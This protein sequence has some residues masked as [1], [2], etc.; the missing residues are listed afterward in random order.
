MNL[1]GQRLGPYLLE[2]PV[3]S[4]AHG[5]VWR[6]SRSD[7]LPVA[8]K[9]ARDAVGKQA[10]NSEIEALKLLGNHPNIV[11]PLS[12]DPGVEPPYIA[13]ALQP[14]GTLRELLNRSG[15]T[16][17]QHGMALAGSV[18]AGL[19]H[20]HGKGITHGDVKPENVMLDAMGQPRLGDFG[21]S[22]TTTPSLSLSG[23]LATTGAPTGTVAYM[24]PSQ[25]SGHPPRPEDDAYSLG[26]EHPSKVG[27]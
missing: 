24:S 14:G 19:R 17:A 8:V 23:A 22:R 21:L 9:V 13:F 10:L 18:L 15:R 7:G 12:A 3:G 20:A 25:A 11:P 26:R 5:E 27:D 16:T 4:G 6:G 2:A 1:A